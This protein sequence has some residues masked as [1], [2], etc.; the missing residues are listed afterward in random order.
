MSDHEKDDIICF[1]DLNF[2]IFDKQSTQDAGSRSLNL[3]HSKGHNDFRCALYMSF[4]RPF[5]D[6]VSASGTW[7]EGQKRMPRGTSWSSRMGIYTE[8]QVPRLLS[9]QHVTPV[10]KWRIA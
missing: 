4:V 9:Q 2:S 6:L 3:T 8:L 1:I 7:K 5:D 10:T